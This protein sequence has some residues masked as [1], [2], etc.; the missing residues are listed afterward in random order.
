M[1]VG[2][3]PIATAELLPCES[4]IYRQIQ[5]ITGWLKARKI[6]HD[7]AIHPKANIALL[8][9]VAPAAQREACRGASHVDPQAASESPAPAMSSRS[10]V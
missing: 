10:S 4:S 1:I 7:P 9:A 5:T 3:C 8:T 2:A 6:G